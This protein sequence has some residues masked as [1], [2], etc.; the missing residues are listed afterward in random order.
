MKYL[1]LIPFLLASVS[2]AQTSFKTL[3]KFDTKTLDFKMDHFST[4]ELS[5]LRI[6]LPDQSQWN[7]QNLQSEVKLY[8]P[9]QYNP[10]GYPMND[11]SDMDNL[12]MGTSLLTSM[13]LGRKSLRTTY[14]FDLQG[15]LRSS[16]FTITKKKRKR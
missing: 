2:H 5:P 15:N 14:I 3:Q 6:N 10:T 4:R 11:L 9:N 16:E 1:A 12:L 13:E 7:A 8:T